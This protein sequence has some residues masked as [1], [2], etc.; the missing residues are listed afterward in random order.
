MLHHS[1]TQETRTTDVS[2]V[3]NIL[4]ISAGDWKLANKLGNHIV[5]IVRLAVGREERKKLG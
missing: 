2:I 4:F 3:G 1:P 5:Y